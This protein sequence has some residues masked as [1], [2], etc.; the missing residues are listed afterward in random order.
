MDLNQ[1]LEQ[2]YAKFSAAHEAGDGEVARALKRYAEELEAK[3]EAKEP[4]KSPMY[5]NAYYDP[6]GWLADKAEGNVPGV[7]SGLLRMGSAEGQQQALQ[8]LTLGTSD[9]IQSWLGEKFGI[10]SAENLQAMQERDRDRFKREYPGPA[11]A[12]EMAGAVAGPGKVLSFAKT[13]A[14][15]MGTGL[16]EGMIALSGYT[17]AETPGELATEAAITLPLATLAPPLLSFGGGAAVNAAAQIGGM[18]RRRIFSDTGEAEYLLDRAVR[19]DMG[20]D[21]GALLERMDDLG[22]EGVLADAGPNLRGLGANAGMVP[23]RGRQAALETVEQRNVGAG[24]RVT[25]ATREAVGPQADDYYGFQRSIQERRRAGAQADYDRA[26]SSDYTPSDRVISDIFETG[27]GRQAQRR[28]DRLMEADG[29]RQTAPDPDGLP[30][31]TS[32]HRNTRYGDYLGRALRDMQDEAFR[33]GSG[34]L[35]N[36]IRNM[37]SR[38]NDDLYGQVPAL[39]A[40]RNQYAG[41]SRLIEAA[42]KGRD[43]FK[44]GKFVEDIDELT[45][46]YTEGEMEAFRVGAFNALTREVRRAASYSGDSARRLIGTPRM[47]EIVESVVPDEQARVDLI[48]RLLAERDM[49]ATMRLTAPDT[50][51]RTPAMQHEMQAVRSGDL[52]SWIRDLFSPGMTPE[53]SEQL[54]DVLFGKLSREELERIANR[55]MQQHAA[56]QGALVDPAGQAVARYLSPMAFPYAVR[57]VLEQ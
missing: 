40:A 46:D 48:R 2:T 7:V 44:G 24:Q 35:G 25:Q 57:P 38:L 5:G 36:A 1:E 50:Q 42:E 23:G 45:R 47:Q 51:S 32:L 6:V 31:S 13:P 56:G 43:I 28:A 49:N 15:M 21:P 14:Q 33:S 9:E 39:Q 53:V 10:D 12:S 37:R 41:E 11:L 29:F 52:F 22:P 20:D 16:G 54:V 8:G 4:P 27:I 19:A 17:E 30:G 3:R 34:S 18:A 26:Y 55:A